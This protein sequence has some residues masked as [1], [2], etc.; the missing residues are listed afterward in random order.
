[1]TEPDSLTEHNAAI[2]DA[3]DGLADAALD[4]HAAHGS[5]PETLGLYLAADDYAIAVN[6]RAEWRA[7]VHLKP[8]AG[9]WP[10]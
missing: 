9:G 6:A 5:L 3:L 8:K 7:K 4:Y 1:M 10:T 2:E